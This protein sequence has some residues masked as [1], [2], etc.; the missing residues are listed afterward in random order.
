MRFGPTVLLAAML[1][2]LPVRAER[3]LPQ[4]NWTHGEVHQAVAETDPL[5]SL[6]PF[7]ELARSHQDTMLLQELNRLAKDDSVLLPV[8]ERLL[9][10]FAISLSDLDRLAVGPAVL[11]FLETYQPRVLVPHEDS[12]QL[13]IPMYNIRAA[14]A[15]VRHEW[16]W[17]AG[18]AEAMALKAA[19]GGAWLAAYL[20]TGPAGR[21]GYLDRLDAISEPV[22]RSLAQQAADRLPD[23][24][25]LTPIVSRAALL[26]SDVELLQSAV[27][28][29]TGPGLATAL[30]MAASALN[31]PERADL[32][33][34]AVRHAPAVNAA[35]A[36]AELSPGLLHRPETIALLFGL[37]EDPELGAASALALSRSPTPT[38]RAQLEELAAQGLGT[39]S[40]RA[41]VA[42]TMARGAPAEEE[43]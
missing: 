2:C 18:A 14:A 21:N 27:A 20:S 24:P 22:L 40:R 6:R 25:D 26:L 7:L 3:A 5:E 28:Q 11:E 15:G 32:L 17:Q 39:A 30:R 19:P 1:A 36:L 42:A 10:E 9:F 16:Q 33:E 31:E 35:L 41:A 13:G 23:E 34:H 37:L 29:G 43:R 8:R 12:R 38:V 4:P